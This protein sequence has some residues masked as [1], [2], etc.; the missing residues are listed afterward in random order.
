MLPGSQQSKAD[1]DTFCE[2]IGRGFF[3]TL[4]GL[5]SKKKQ[6]EKA[7]D[8]IYIKRCLRD[9]ITKYN[10]WTLFGS[11]LQPTWGVRG[12]E[13]TRET[14][15]WTTVKYQEIINFNDYYIGIIVI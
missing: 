12:I 3:N 14:Y 13:A 5:T 10:K 1:R 8:L 11:W 15:R 2:T 7:N 6:E 4:L 9:I